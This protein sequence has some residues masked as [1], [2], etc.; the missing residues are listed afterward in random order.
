ME[1]LAWYFPLVAPYE[2]TLRM[3]WGTLV[4]PIRIGVE[5]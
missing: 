2:T 4:L 3:H 1:V 5:R